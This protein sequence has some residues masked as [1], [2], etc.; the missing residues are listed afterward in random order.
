M[1]RRTQAGLQ[2]L[3]R[4]RGFEEFL[5]RAEK[6][7][8]ERLPGDTLHRFLPWAVALGVSDRWILNFQGLKV[9][10]P[11]WF[12]GREAFSLSLYQL[13]LANFFHQTQEAIPAPRRFAGAARAQP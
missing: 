13:D 3:A 1:P 12:T 2:A 11:A 8:L 4:V 9:D 10:P 5:L 6:D 7:R